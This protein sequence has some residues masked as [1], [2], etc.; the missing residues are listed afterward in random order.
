MV[1]F[2]EA[3]PARCQYSDRPG[4]VVTVGDASRFTPCPM[5]DGSRVASCCDGAVW[6]DVDV[7]DERTVIDDA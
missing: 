3:Q 2:R 1:K 6:C 4:F 5:C 7:I